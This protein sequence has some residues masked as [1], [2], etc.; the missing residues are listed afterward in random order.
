MAGL[1]RPGDVIDGRY[2]VDEVIGVGGMSVVVGAHPVGSSA[3]HPRVAV[4]L[5]SPELRDRPG[6]LA[7]FARE[8]RAAGQIQSEHAARVLDVAGLD[9]AAPY[10][11]ME[12]LDGDDLGAVLAA[13]GQ[14]P[15]RE[16]VGYVLEA[17]E[18]LAE[19]HARGIVHR[20]LKPENLFR[21]VQPDGSCRIKVLDFGVS[22]LKRSDADAEGSLTGPDEMLGS[23]RYMA[24][25]Q[26]RSAKDA[27]PRADIWALGVLLY[28]ML[29]GS[30]P[31]PGETVAAATT[32]IFFAP[33]APLL[34]LS[35]DVPPALEAVILSCLEKDRERRPP[36]LP[37]LGRA[38]LPFA[39]QVAAPAWLRPRGPWRSLLA[40]LA[41]WAQRLRSP[42]AS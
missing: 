42:A 11:V 14:L 36:D 24:P 10:L 16:A 34:A 37:S 8:A 31:F 13:R 17:G 22:K 4:K 3:H 29:A 39:G 5:L 35:P 19:A 40:L 15:V 7:R 32:Q 41:R 12:R 27:D 20:D 23:P 30:L 6:A 21:A 2:V 28:R 38:L 1:P 25:E 9:A 33:P 18:A 26:I